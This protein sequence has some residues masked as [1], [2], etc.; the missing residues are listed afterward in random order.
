MHVELMS[1]NREC[2]EQC[3]MGWLCLLLPSCWT[4]LQISLQLFML[5]FLFSQGCV[6]LVWKQERLELPAHINNKSL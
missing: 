6:F 5:K 2:N 4:S 3:Y 1:F